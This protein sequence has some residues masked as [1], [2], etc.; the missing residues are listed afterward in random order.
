MRKAGGDAIRRSRRARPHAPAGA[1]NPLTA[2]TVSSESDFVEL[3]RSPVRAGNHL[4]FLDVV[5]RQRFFDRT[6]WCLDGNV[7]IGNDG[8]VRIH[9][10]VLSVPNPSPLRPG[11]VAVCVPV[12]ACRDDELD[13][14]SRY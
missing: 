7:G 12:P 4:I 1:E 10:G 11:G 6:H 3:S 8:F 13:R 2:N 9:A 5:G 14:L